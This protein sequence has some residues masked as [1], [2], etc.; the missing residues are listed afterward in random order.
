MLFMSFPVATNM[1]YVLCSRRYNQTNKQK[2]HQ[3]YSRVQLFDRGIQ[4]KNE[5]NYIHMTS[6]A[7]DVII[8]CS[9][10]NLMTSF[11]LITQILVYVF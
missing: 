6:N 11:H 8:S 2:Y 7:I 1:F 5:T 4:M 10:T 3:F 9:A